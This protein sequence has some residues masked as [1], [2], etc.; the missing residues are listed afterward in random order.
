MNYVS[1]GDG[2]RADDYD[3][4]I[5]IMD[6]NLWWQYVIT[7]VMMLA[8]VG[9]DNGDRLTQRHN[10][11]LL[12]GLFSSIVPRTRDPGYDV[13]KTNSGLVEDTGYES[14]QTSMMNKVVLQFM[15]EAP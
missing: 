9:T 13:S 4:G 12:Q 2:G 8:V 5:D 14:R 11:T 10:S 7:T 6:D 3:S 1:D 15:L